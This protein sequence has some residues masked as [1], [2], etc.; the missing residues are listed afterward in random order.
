MKIL[1]LHGYGSKFDPD[2]TKIGVLKTLGQVSGPNLDYGEGQQAVFDAVLAFVDN[3]RYDLVVG[4][5]MGGW[6]ASH[7]CRL[8]QVPFVALN[9]AITPSRTL[10]KYI[11]QTINYV[12]HDCRID[13]EAVMSYADFYTRGGCGYILCEAGDEVLDA[14]TTLD[15]LSAYYGTKLID[16][17]SHRFESLASHLSQLEQMAT[18]GASSK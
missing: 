1:Y 17:G 18:A 13:E 3:D 12:G 6:L 7:V 4:T 9:P 14:R 8:L 11:G 2:S 16:G 15:Y 5:S 10:K